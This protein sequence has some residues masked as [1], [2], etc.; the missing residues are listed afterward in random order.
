MKI[1]VNKGVE[2]Y[3]S[4]INNDMYIFDI[5]D[6]INQFIVDYEK[7][8]NFSS[9]DQKTYTEIINSTTGLETDFYI[10]KQ[11]LINKKGGNDEKQ[12]C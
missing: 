6:E 8:S 4:Y 3:I 9:N 7:F 1:F 10:S 11:Y 5:D 12:K 2:S